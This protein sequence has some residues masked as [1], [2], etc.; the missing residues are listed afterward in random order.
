MRMRGILIAG[1]AGLALA[2]CLVAARSADLA[3]AYSGCTSCTGPGPCAACVPACKAT[4]E[5]KKASKPAYSMKCEYAC[6]RARDSWHAP[7][8]ECR[9]SPPCGNV[10][11]KKRLF[12]VD[13]EPKVEKVP[14]YEV[15]MVPG[16]PC[17]CAACRGAGPL[18]WINPLNL[19]H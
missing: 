15:Q 6:D 17:D 18:C 4:W 13:G 12:K 9:C 7:P 3:E 1:L 11:V 10:Y 8:P 19:L 5:E 14:K 16:E 2:S